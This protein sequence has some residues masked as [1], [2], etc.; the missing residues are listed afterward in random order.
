GPLPA[1]PAPTDEWQEAL[2]QARQEAEE[3]RA[4]AIEMHRRLV[5]V[6][7]EQE[8]ERYR[9]AGVPPELL[10]V[11]QPL[12]RAGAG[13]RVDG[14]AVARAML[15]FVRDRYGGDADHPPP[16]VD[17]LLARWDRPRRPDGT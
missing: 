13:D 12:L 3:A 8:R 11:A 15:D 14:G 6:T 4:V 16:D 10:D 17:R 9:L 1:P 7:V 5:N 2:R